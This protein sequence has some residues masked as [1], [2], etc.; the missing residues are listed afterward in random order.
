MVFDANTVILI[1]NIAIIFTSSLAQFYSKYPKKMYV[2]IQ[3]GK[4]S[5]RYKP[6]ITLITKTKQK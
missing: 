2:R 4:F 1:Q 3:L 6:I 5:L